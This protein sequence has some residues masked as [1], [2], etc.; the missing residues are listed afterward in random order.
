MSVP[1]A[2][3]S[4]RFTAPPWPVWVAAVGVVVLFVLFPPFHLRRIGDAATNANSSGSPGA[5]TVNATSAPSADPAVFVAQFWTEKL[6]P[7]ANAAP[8]LAPI[9]TA[10]RGDALAAR[11]QFGRQ[12]GAGT[13]WYYFARGSGRVTAVE[14][15]RVL[16]AVDGTAG[17]IVALRTGPVFGNVVRDGCGLLELNSVPG[18]AEFNALSAELNR[19]VEETVQPSLRT[20]VQVGTTLSFA[21]CAEAP[22]HA[23]D[24][25]LLVIVPVRAEVRP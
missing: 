14:K 12:V 24:G 3:G 13:T 19:R 1:S 18:L 25:P 22:E 16:V 11:K 9:V 21:G 8:E 15:S 10:I 6:Q 7:A 5:P 17:L 4:A 2:S 20:G 23:G